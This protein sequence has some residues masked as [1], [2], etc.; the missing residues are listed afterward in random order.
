MKVEK[1]MTK[2]L[3]KSLIKHKI[4]KKN[5]NEFLKDYPKELIDRLE[6]FLNEIIVV[7]GESI[8]KETL[9]KILD[10]KIKSFEVDVSPKNLES[11]YLNIVENVT[12]DLSNRLGKKI[13]FSFDN[14]DNES[15]N[16][17]RK[18]FYWM[19][20]DYNNRLQNELKDIIEDTFRGDVP[21]DKVAQVLRE[22]FLDV[23]KKSEDYF[24]GV[25]EHISLQSQNVA[26][27]IQALKYDVK[28]FKVIAK[29]DHR[30]SAICRS[31]H[32]RIIPAEHLERQVD[33]ILSAKSIDEKKDAATWMNKPFLG[34]NLP[35]NFGLPPY[36]FRCRTEVVP[37][38]IN[39]DEIDGKIVKYTEKNE[40]D[41]LRLI[42]NTGVERRI[43]KQNWEQH[44]SVSRKGKLKEKDII[45][46]L[47][48]I[49]EIS[50]HAKDSNRTV[51]KTQNGYF[52]V[53]DGDEIVTIF[54]SNNL[55]K[56]F[57]N[58]A[59]SVQ[60]VVIKWD[61]ER[62]KSQFIKIIAGK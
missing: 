16:A 40:D 33:K 29:M 50:P 54:K 52:I 10:E 60:K 5:I 28:Y 55:D 6:T 25:A 42:D 58:N 43:T 56:Y 23:T 24:R 41:F 27:V 22:H 37:V 18:S 36:H 11:V 3:I 57:K 4:I 59:N 38:W 44:I 13:N 26:R 2:N 1:A 39:E 46:A 35:Q 45:A 8:D 14:I 9:K 62:L 15:I 20:K 31:M 34:K 12:K 32:G 48:S 53:F 21:N 7:S 51:A 61:L 47:N 30:T 17:M 49:K 19:G